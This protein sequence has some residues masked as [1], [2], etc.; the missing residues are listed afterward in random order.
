VSRRE[1]LLLGLLCV[2]PPLVAQLRLPA[3]RIDSDAVEYY[4]H[5]RSLY[6]DRDLDLANEF[7]H[8]GVLT[9]AD[10]AQPTRTGMRRSIYAIGPSL[11][12]LPFYAAGDLVARVRGALE[13]GYSEAHIRAVCLG[14]LVYGAAGLLLLFG[15][16]RELVPR[17][18]AV[19]AAL[20]VLYAT[21]LYWYLVHEP[22]MSHAASFFMAAAVLRVWW[23]G[24]ERLSLR[25]AAALGLLIGLAACVRW[26]NAVL[27]LL[28]A[29]TLARALRGRPLPAVGAGVLTLLAFGV[30]AL[31]QML[32]WKTLF[33]E[34]LL[35]EPPQGRD[36]LRLEHP[37]LLETFFSSRHGL[38]FWTP[39]L[40]AGYLGY[41]GL[42][43]RR[44]FLAIACGL[45]LLVMSYVNACSGDWW[46]GGSFS[47]RRFD[48]VLPLLALGLAVALEWLRGV[49]ARRPALPLALGA[50]G[51]ALWNGLFMEQYRRN[52][53]P[54]D[55]VVSFARV[56]ENSAALVTELVGTPLAWPANWIFAARHRA[57]LA[58]HD[59]ASGKYLFYKMNNL[60]GVIDLGDARVDP[61]LLLEGWARVRPCDG[62]E[63]RGLD[64][65]AR[66]LFPLDVPEELD[67]VV[68][69]RGGAALRLAVNGH[70]LAELPLAEQLVERRARVPATFLRREHNELRLDSDAAD[71]LI[72]RVVFRRLPRAEG[73]R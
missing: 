60:G 5:L 54:R 13:D 47:N 64:G 68:R 70:A 44:P 4:S 18:A 63:C 50:G 58:S 40:W 29:A 31:P 28:P 26:Q 69:A 33:G 30:G 48:S 66:L 43:R 27:L 41:L 45:P 20:L 36:F 7:E 16:L 24:R 67:L 61:A 71:V 37:F 25:R 39:L 6:Q 65:P 21:F 51:L 23:T 55:D 38:L 49:L 72:D 32:A 1:L 35:A 3:P 14:S 52:L 73:T 34:Y 42:A 2:V 22:L 11:L 53:I 17:G 62:A 56:T 46:A 8:F 12:W 10:K 19:A 15:V 57:P 9:R 59:L